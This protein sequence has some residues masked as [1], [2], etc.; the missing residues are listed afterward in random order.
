MKLLFATHNKN[1]LQEVKSLIPETLDLLGLSDVAMH[2]EIPETATTL[3]GNALLKARTIYQKTGVNCLADDSGLEVEA[4]DGAP[5]VYSARYAGETKSDEANIDKLLRELQGH[6]NR[7]ARFRTVIALIVNGH[8]TLFEGIIQG[9]ITTERHGN[10]GFGYDPVFIPENHEVT[11]AQMT[12]A[13]KNS[14]SHRALATRKLTDYLNET[15][16]S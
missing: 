14:I 3:E 10:H 6:S 7:K 9:T 15:F 11:F 8:E 16:R 4:L 13:E 2:D 1:K 5:G 12:L